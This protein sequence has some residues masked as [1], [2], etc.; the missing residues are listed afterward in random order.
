[1][2]LGDNWNFG[3]KRQTPMLKKDQ[4][5]T[6]AFRYGLIA[7]SSLILTGCLE[8]T[9]QH[10]PLA[11]FD[12]TGS[13]SDIPDAEEAEEL[14]REGLK[15]ISTSGDHTC[16]IRH[17]NNALNCWGGNDRAQIGNNSVIDIGLPLVV[18]SYRDWRQVSAGLKHSCGI[19]DQNILQK[20]SVGNLEIVGLEYSLWCWGDNSSNQLGL[21]DKNSDGIPD[22]DRQRVPGRIGE[23]DDWSLA[24]AGGPHSCAIRAEETTGTDESGNTVVTNT[25]HTLWCWGDNRFGQ[26]GDG[27]TKMVFLPKQVDANTDWLMMSLGEHHSCGIRDDDGNNS[28]WCW[29]QNTFNQL[30]AITATDPQVTPHK[31]DDNSWASVSSAK[32]HSCAIRTDNS[33]WCWGTNSFGQLGNNTNID[34]VVPIQVTTATDWQS[35]GTGSLHTCAAKLNGSLWCWGNNAFGQLALEELSHQQLP[36]QIISDT[37]FK[38][39]STGEY[40]TCAMDEDDLAH[41]WGLN[42]LGQI[43]QDTLANTRLPRTYNTEDWSDIASGRDFSCGIKA[44][45]DSLWC[46]GLNNNGQLGDGTPLHRPS[47]VLVKTQGDAPTRWASV[48]IGANQTCAIQEDETLWCWGANESFQL[49]HDD[50][51]TPIEHGPNYFGHWEPNEI[52]VGATSFSWIEVSA[53]LHHSCALKRDPTGFTPWC[54]GN[55]TFGQLG[56]NTRIAQAEPTQVSTNAD[57][58]NISSNGGHSCGIR[59]TSILPLRRE[60]YCWGRN[61]AGQVGNGSNDD[62]LQPTRIGSDHDWISIT[63]GAVHSCGIREISAIPQ[64]RALFCWGSNQIGQLGFENNQ[65]NA[66]VPT[67]VDESTNWGSVYAGEFSNCGTRL[68]NTPQVFCWGDNRDQQSSL[69]FTSIAEVPVI[70]AGAKRWIDIAVG[71]S[72]TCALYKTALG[73]GEVQCWGRTA[74]YQLGDD[75]AWITTPKA[76]PLK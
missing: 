15:L 65:T 59:E 44:E 74:Q 4:H 67:Q 52:T 22:T 54:W 29:G 5:I 23:G 27:D 56:N 31:V 34:S 9:A 12:I 19:R 64:E 42:T 73:Q 47:P 39:V 66:I 40:H 37:I 20:D 69:S 50:S 45:D 62:V 14:R 71:A 51:L 11:E 8:P 6:H 55:N 35:V 17:I 41:C 1:M 18:S 63:T 49:G 21:E 57:W 2:K 33:L 7:L 25:D 3:N 58:I 30:G 28:L 16:T 76:I 43:G 75:N 24:Y 32:K 10:P 48:S 70:M 68:F 53:G 13:L 60:L 36:Q 46:G 38:A 72:H 61:N 26:L